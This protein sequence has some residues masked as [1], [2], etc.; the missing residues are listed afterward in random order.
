MQLFSLRSLSVPVCFFQCWK[1]TLSGSP[2]LREYNYKHKAKRK[3]EFSRISSGTCVDACD[4]VFITLFSRILCVFLI[5]QPYDYVI[6]TKCSLYH[7]KP[8]EEP[9]YWTRFVKLFFGPDY[10]QLLLE[11]FDL[12]FDVMSTYPVVDIFLCFI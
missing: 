7:W 2:R 8:Y 12:D 5:D 11:D 4:E 1:A 6:G 3:A 10:Y 9:S